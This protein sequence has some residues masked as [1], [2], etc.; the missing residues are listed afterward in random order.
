MDKIIDLFREN[1]QRIND[2]HKIYH[3]VSKST[4]HIINAT[5][6]LRAELVLVVSAFD[7]Y[8]HG[9]VREGMI[10]VFEGNRIE[11]S[12]F[13]KVNISL[14]SVQDAIH[15]PLSIDWLRN[16]IINKHSWQ[17][18]QRTEKVS[19]AI[20]LIS[21]TELWNEVANKLNDDPK[22]IKNKLNLIIDRRNKIAHEADID[23]SNPP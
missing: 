10:D 20:H 7:F 11:T 23:F 3:V 12:S 16:E 9:L 17:S 4:T 6:I 5:D 15:N 22:Y 19:E 13:K 2:L 21:D 14:E 1:I 18:F 8:I